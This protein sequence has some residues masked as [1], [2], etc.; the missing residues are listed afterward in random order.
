MTR[1]RLLFV[2]M[3]ACAPLPALAT[4]HTWVVDQLYSNADGT[5]QFVVLREAQGAT[6]ENLLGG[7]TLVATHGGVAKTFTFDHDLPSPA[8][9]GKHVLIA[10]TGVAALGVVAP[11]YVMPVRFLPTDGGSVN[12]ADVNVL[13]YTALPVDGASALA[14]SPGFGLPVA[15]PNVATNFAGQSASL[16]PGPI[17]VVEY[18]NPSLDHYFMS[19]L[20]PD[21]DALDSGRIAGWQ[22][23]GLQFAAQPPQPNPPASLSPVC[24][25]YIPPQHGDSHFFSAS[26]AEC[27]AIVSKIVT[28]PNYSGYIRETADAFFIDL[29]DTATGACL[30]GRIPVYRLWNGRADSNHRY[31]TRAD[32]RDAMIARGYIPEGYG[33]DGV[34]MCATAAALGDSLV[35][36]TGTTPY[37]A[38]CD[39][40]APTGLLFAGAEVEPMIA[41]SPVQLG[42]IATYVGVWQQ[43]RWSDGGARGLRTG[44]SSDGGL[45]WGT[46][47]AKFTRCSG[48]TPANGGDFPR[49]S[50]PWV[51]FAADGTALQIAIAFN[52]GTFAA[53]SSSAVL[54]SRSVDGGRTWSDPATLIR[55]GSTAFNDK[56]S[57]TGDRY[58]PGIAYATWDRLVQNGNGPAYFARTQDNGL[59]WE[60]ARPIYD[61]GPRNQTLNNQIVVTP[62]GANASPYTAFNFFTEID[63]PANAPQTTRLAVI[64]SS[65]HGTTWTPPLYITDIMARG[66]TNPQTGGELRDGATLGSFAGGANGQL[67]AVWQD[68][69][70]SAGARD[71]VAFS[72]SLDG[73]TTWSTPVQVNSVPGTQALIPS[74]TIRD[75]GTYGV[76]YYDMRNDTSDPATL[77]V[78]AWLTTSVDGVTWREQHMGGPFD[79]A[80]A[81][82]A[83]GLFIGDYQ[84]LASDGS[85]FVPIFVQTNPGRVAD[86]LTDVFAGVVRSVPP[87]SA[88]AAAV[89]S[90]APYKARAAPA[91]VPDAA[92][93]AR[94]AATIA[95]VLEGRQMRRGTATPP[96][97]R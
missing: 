36:V 70:F 63:S 10:T 94:F 17:T 8:T 92:L 97:E 34:A 66:T 59:T 86:N 13:T 31:T 69:R 6:G 5:L 58:A 23:T 40:V 29:P 78:D 91:F 19:P 75:D 50:D 74:V 71:G 82:F 81:P 77:I 83:E 16:V 15:V 80:S 48:G 25:F 43:D 45:T 27:A 87:A 85:A 88:V 73:G 64:R 57:I 38:G 2:L 90:G 95:R 21:I 42:G 51:T 37:A 46:A 54:A 79:F 33:P 76:L 53:G 26:P 96:V 72:R 30:P 84:G 93:R 68:A 47:Q 49:A 18:Y 32:V 28:D 65:D 3:L 62:P 9:A 67:V 89:K 24:R 55:D 35:K 56:E 61:P 14:P 41:A 22:R 44:F 39:G 52:G 60:P 7:H 4:Y 12:Y 1:F 11:D 20:A